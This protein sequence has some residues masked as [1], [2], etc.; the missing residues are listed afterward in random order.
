MFLVYLLVCV[1]LF[2]LSYTPIKRKCGSQGNVQDRRNHAKYEGFRACGR[3]SQ[4]IPHSKCG[5]ER[6]L[7]RR[8]AHG[9]SYVWGKC[10]ASFNP[11]Y[12]TLEERRVPES[13]IVMDLIESLRSKSLPGIGDFTR[14]THTRSANGGSI[15]SVRVSDDN[16][17]RLILNKKLN[18]YDKNNHL[19]RVFMFDESDSTGT[20]RYARTSITI[21]DN[22]RQALQDCG[23][24]WGCHGRGRDRHLGQKVQA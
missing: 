10:C 15:S 2:L 17:F 5:F 12:S 24:E 18:L 14:T 9:F 3:F 8:L 4:E 7:Y 11:L 19:M 20:I 23:S 21:I 1:V 6:I 13:E 16:I 22:T